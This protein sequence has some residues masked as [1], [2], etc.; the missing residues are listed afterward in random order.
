MSGFGP[1]YDY[2]SRF[3]TLLVIYQRVAPTPAGRLVMGYVVE[4]A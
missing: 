4:T 2:L 1:E 3:L